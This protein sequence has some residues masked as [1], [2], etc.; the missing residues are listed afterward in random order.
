MARKE[1][2]QLSGTH[3]LIGMAILGNLLVAAFL[4][5]YH[6]FA[7]F[8]LEEQDLATFT[9]AQRAEREVKEDIRKLEN[10]NSW[11]ETTYAKKNPWSADEVK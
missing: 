7:L 4:Y 1:I 3:I 2:I 6:S 5:R 11:N 8:R 9:A 10:K